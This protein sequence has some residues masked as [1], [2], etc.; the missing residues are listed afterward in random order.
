M[1]T[2]I[3]SSCLRLSS[4]DFSRPCGFVLP[5]SLWIRSPREPILLLSFSCSA[6][7]ANGRSLHHFSPVSSRLV[8]RPSG[9]KRRGKKNRA[10]NHLSLLFNACCGGG[11][12]IGACGRPSLIHFESD[13]NGR[14]DPP[15]MNDGRDLYTRP[16]VD[17][18]FW[19]FMCVLP[20][21]ERYGFSSSAV[22]ATRDACLPIQQHT[23]CRLA[24]IGSGAASIISLYLS[25]F[26]LR[27]ACLPPPFFFFFFALCADVVAR[28]CFLRVHPSS[29]QRDQSVSSVDYLFLSLSSI[30]FVCFIFLISFEVVSAHKE[31]WWW[32]VGGVFSFFYHR[33]MRADFPE[34]SRVLTH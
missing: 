24:I 18:T 31:I 27:S 6:A 34:P 30:F 8:T 19:R 5:R 15:G 33:V 16:L 14:Q 26:L 20:G 1:T 9:C 28:A 29:S 22:R 12:H 2:T 13:G 32:W 21:D 23:V 17:L 25:P 10:Q 7:D 11:T 4:R 3:S